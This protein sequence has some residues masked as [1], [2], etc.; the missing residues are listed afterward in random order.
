MRRRD[1]SSLFSQAF[2]YTSLLKCYCSQQYPI[3]SLYVFQQSRP[4]RWWYQPLVDRH[5]LRVGRL[6]QCS[7]QW[8]CC[9]GLHV[10]SN[11][12]S[13]E[14]LLRHALCSSFC[15]PTSSLGR[16]GPSISQPFLFHHFLLFPF[17]FLSFL[18]VTLPLSPASS[19][20]ECVNLSPR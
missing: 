19:N 2:W 3:E 13:S 9:N 5:V 6:V 18:T 17:P 11:Y 16:S 10:V 1:L 7:R 8:H 12:K 14:Y 4:H 20:A 15:S